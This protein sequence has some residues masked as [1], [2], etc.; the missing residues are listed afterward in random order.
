MKILIIRLI[1]W[2]IILTIIGLIAVQINKFEPELVKQL[3]IEAKNITT[4]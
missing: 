4:R 1:E 2:L 3:A